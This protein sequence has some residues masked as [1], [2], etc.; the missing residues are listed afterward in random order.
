MIR[1][2]TEAD[3]EKLLEIYSY[4]I[5]NTAITFEWEVPSVEEFARRIRTVT[6]K[7]PFL[8]AETDGEIVG[9]AYAGAFNERRSCDWTVETSIYVAKNRRGCG[10][11][12]ELY[13]ALEKA[14]SM[15]NIISLNAC[16]AYPENEDEYLTKNSVRYHEHMGYRYVGEFHRCGY[17]FGRW[18]SLVWLEKFIAEHSKFPAEV[19]WFPEIRDMLAKIL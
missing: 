16:V 19:K 18:Y 17:K 6:E 7:Y 5:R 9:Y 14:L 11:G 13:T 2:A 1:I 15:Q 3:A 4:Y 12:R 8:L 10:V